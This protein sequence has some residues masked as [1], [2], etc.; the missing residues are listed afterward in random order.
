MLCNCLFRVP[1][2]KFYGFA[3]KLS[4][5]RCIWYCWHTKDVSYMICYTCLWSVSVHAFTYVPTTVRPR[6]H[7]Q[8]SD[9]PVADRT[10]ET[11]TWNF[12]NISGSNRPIERPTDQ[13]RCEQAVVHAQWSVMDRN[14][15]IALLLYRRRTVCIGFIQW[16]IK[17]KNS[18]P[19]THYLTNY[20][21]TQTSFKIIFESQFYLST[22]CI[23]K[24]FSVIA[25][26]GSTCRKVGS[27]NQV[28]NISV[29]FKRKIWCLNK[30]NYFRNWNLFIDTF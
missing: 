5:R 3:M 6:S 24:V 9:R 30:T 10:G 20:E 25:V 22:S 21:M 8:V 13:E 29:C 17:G 7:V 18:V 16:F 27:C 11:T 1:Y 28:S 14:W 2:F 12:N 23:R 26:K 19:F 4:Q 15:I